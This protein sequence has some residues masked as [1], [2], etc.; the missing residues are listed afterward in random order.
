MSK[1][2]VLSTKI[3]GFFFLNFYFNFEAGIL[4]AFKTAVKLVILFFDLKIF[5]PNQ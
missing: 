3:S 5:F 4:G 1:H 2:A